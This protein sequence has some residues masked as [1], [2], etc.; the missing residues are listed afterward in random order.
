MLSHMAE[1][2]EMI[3]VPASQVTCKSNPPNHGR[4]HVA[5]GRDR[6][7]G[8]SSKHTGARARAA[9]EALSASKRTRCGYCPRSEVIV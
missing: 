2:L 6:R 9:D 8:Q 3:R 4:P 5:D 1:D 7:Y